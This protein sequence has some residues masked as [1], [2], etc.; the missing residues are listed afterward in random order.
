MA[1]NPDCRFWDQGRCREG[2]RRNPTYTQCR[3]CRHRV[4]QVSAAT[5][6]AANPE[7]V[8][9]TVTSRV[10]PDAPTPRIGPR[11]TRVFALAQLLEARRKVCDAC[12]HAW[13]DDGLPVTKCTEHCCLPALQKDP[14]AQCRLGFWR[15]I[16]AAPV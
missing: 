12:S 11:P 13:K 2:H 8:G 6:A 10:P 7:P 5:A 14:L 9:S 1:F 16:S 3:E 4:R 15:S